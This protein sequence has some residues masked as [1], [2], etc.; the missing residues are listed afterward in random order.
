MQIC[1][2]IDPYA[3][4]Y[5]SYEG[6]TYILNSDSISLLAG[7]LGA[8]ILELDGAINSDDNWR[9][10]RSGNNLLFQVKISGTWTTAFTRERP[11]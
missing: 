11:V 3:V 4:H 1:P 7:V 2:I 8:D 10:T 6:G 5:D 9:L